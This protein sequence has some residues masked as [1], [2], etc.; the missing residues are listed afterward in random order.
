MGPDLAP[1]L[2]DKKDL[3]KEFKLLRWVF[4][5]EV[6]AAPAR[7]Q[8][9]SGRL[10]AKRVGTFAQEWKNEHWRYAAPISRM[11][12]RRGG[13]WGETKIIPKANNPPHLT[14]QKTKEKSRAQARKIKQYWTIL[15][16]DMSP[17]PYKNN[18]N[19]CENQKGK[20]KKKKKRRRRR[21]N[22]RTTACKIHFNGTPPF[23]IV[24]R[25]LLT[26]I[27]R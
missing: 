8:E 15:R 4:V 10:G 25:V 6:L 1:E 26:K 19:N 3:W 16:K 20:K 13:G 18:R 5:L 7:I 11:Q 17:L 27:A 9:I 12:K 2:I 24:R 23:D 22:E 21:T 14:P